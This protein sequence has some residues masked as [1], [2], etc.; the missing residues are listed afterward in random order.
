MSMTRTSKKG[1]TW[2]RVEDVVDGAKVRFEVPIGASSRFAA[3]QERKHVR[4]AKK[5]TKGKASKASPSTAKKEPT[6]STAKKEPA[7]STAKKSA[8]AGKKS[9]AKASA[10]QLSLM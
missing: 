10:T 4:A 7:K 6:K 8:S 3:K 2:Q 1:I 5:K 9:K